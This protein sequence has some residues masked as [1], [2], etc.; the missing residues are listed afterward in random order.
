MKTPQ[1][2]P[3]PNPDWKDILLTGPDWPEDFAFPQMD[4]LPEGAE[5]ILESMYGNE[6]WEWELWRQPDGQR[7]FLKVWPFNE[8]A[9]G[10]PDTPGLALTLAETFQ[11][12]MTNWMPREVLADLALHSTTPSQSPSGLN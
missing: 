3:S 12:L 7:Y 10:K 1:P 5:S 11:F 2:K 6:H 4:F 8:G 9:F